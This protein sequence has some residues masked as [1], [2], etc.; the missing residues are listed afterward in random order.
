MNNPALFR[1]P[2]RLIRKHGTR[3][4]FILAEK[5]GIHV[6]IRDFKSQKGAF[7][8]ILNVPFIFINGNMSEEMQRI[9]CAHELGHALLHRKLCRERANM[10]FYEMEMF[11]LKDTTEYE[12]NL[13]AANLLIDTDELKDMIYQGYDIVSIASAMNVNVNL[14]A[15][16][17]TEAKFDGV[18]VP[19][20]P[21]KNFL[22]T[23]EDSAGSV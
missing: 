4:P 19:F 10:A 5:A 3:D 18:T 12:A 20:I 14:L 13:F 17:I 9:V 1:L 6:M 21:K 23:I 7:S 15:I 22:G 2:A 16:K 8:L 11:N